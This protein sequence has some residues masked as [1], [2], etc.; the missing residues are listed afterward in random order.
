M[1]VLALAIVER[2]SYNSALRNQWLNAAKSCASAWI[3]YP[4][5]VEHSCEPPAVQ[6]IE[7]D[8]VVLS[9]SLVR[10]WSVDRLQYH[11]KFKHRLSINRRHD[12]S[13][14][15]PYDGMNIRS[16]FNRHRALPK[17]ELVN[18]KWRLSSL[19][20]LCQPNLTIPTTTNEN[21]VSTFAS[22]ARIDPN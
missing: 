6:N 12:E 20:C 10:F 19:I 8:D 5:I 2:I 17:H 4:D 11:L 21:N 18:P 22:I 16:D 14:A 1:L 7:C 3:N 15:W 13:L 9:W